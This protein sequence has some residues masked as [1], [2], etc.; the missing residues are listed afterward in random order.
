MRLAVVQPKESVAVASQGCISFQIP[1]KEMFALVIANL[2]VSFMTNKT[3]FVLAAILLA[4]NALDL[5]MRI[6][7]NVPMASCKLISILVILN[8]YQ[9]TAT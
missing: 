7:L 5:R 3:T 1:K 9:R 8:V 6:A 2:W 4:V